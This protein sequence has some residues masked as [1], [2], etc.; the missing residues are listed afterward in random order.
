MNARVV[1]TLS[2]TALPLV[3]GG[4]LATAAAEDL[5][6]GPLYSYFEAGYQW[7]DVNYA[8]KQDGGRHEGYKLTGSLG[9]VDFGRAGVHLFGEFF[10]GEF[11]GIRTTCDG[12]EGGTIVAGDRDS[13]SIA[14]GLGA[15][16]A[17]TEKTHLVA[18]AAYVD[19]SE[20]EVPDSTCQLISGDDDGYFVEGMIRS[21]ISDNV[22]IEAG[23][24][25]SDLSDSDISN[26]DVTLG[27]NYAVTD[28]FALHARGIIFDND[29][30]I[31]IGARLNF[32]GLLG[33]DSLF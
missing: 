17:W 19:I 5:S 32:G 7:T 15:H 28:E 18:R 29:T 21:M 8:V 20:F 23:I 12:G 13:Q 3:T 26:T 14:G 1:R 31:E 4:W 24:R 16:F 33:R 30:G 11:T 6:G 25:Y 2:F 27:L 9:L 10:D 22:E